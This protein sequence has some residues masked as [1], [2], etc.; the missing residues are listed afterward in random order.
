MVGDVP[1]CRAEVAFAGR[2]RKDDRNPIEGCLEILEAAP[3]EI[4]HESSLIASVLAVSVA[5]RGGKIRNRQLNRGPSDLSM[6]NYK[7]WCIPAV[8]MP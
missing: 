2:H 4:S 5:D 8:L 7:N 1:T 3:G 6:A